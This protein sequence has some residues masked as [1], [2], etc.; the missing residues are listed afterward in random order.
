MKLSVRETATLLGIT[1]RAV[2]GRIHPR[3]VPGQVGP[4]FSSPI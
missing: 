4:C 1:P 3:R 2:R